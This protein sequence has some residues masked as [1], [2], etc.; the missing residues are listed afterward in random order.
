MPWLPM[1][2]GSG[3]QFGIVVAT[4]FQLGDSCAMADSVEDVTGLDIGA[5]LHVA[6]RDGHGHIVRVNLGDTH[7]QGFGRA[8]G[9]GAGF[10]VYCVAFVTVLLVFDL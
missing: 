2:A 10:V 3:S 9:T 7:G 5:W 6:E 1:L 8:E 4:L